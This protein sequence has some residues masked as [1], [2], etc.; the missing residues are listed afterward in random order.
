MLAALWTCINCSGAGGKANNNFI[1]T[2]FKG[3][4]DV[5]VPPEAPSWCRLQRLGASAVLAKVSEWA[6]GPEI[7]CELIHKSK[8][9]LKASPTQPPG[10]VYLSTTE[11]LEAMK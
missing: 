5:S 7:L 9:F 8:P 1:W 6:K 4:I 11:K 3:S 2:A 10:R